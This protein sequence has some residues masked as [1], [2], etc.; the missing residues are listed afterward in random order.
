MACGIPALVSGDH[1]SLGLNSTVEA[2]V[3]SS[4]LFL[5]LFPNK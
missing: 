5:D 3:H 2:K 1:Y 4:K